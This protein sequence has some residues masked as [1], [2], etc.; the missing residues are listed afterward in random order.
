MGTATVEASNL[1]ASET[2][3]FAVKSVVVLVAGSS[4]LVV[5]GVKAGPFGAK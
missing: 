4:L 5:A 3:G 2:T 1:A